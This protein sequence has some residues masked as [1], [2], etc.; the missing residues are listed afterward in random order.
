MNMSMKRQILVIVILSVFFLSSSVCLATDRLVR[1]QYLTIQDAINASTNGDIVIISPGT[2]T[3][4][5][6][7]DI[8]FGGKAITVKSTDGPET[9]I[10]DVY[11]KGSLHRGFYFH[12]NESSSSVLWGVTITSGRVSGDPAKGGGIYCSGSSPKIENCI[13]NNNSAY[14]T[15]GPSESCVNGGDAYGGAIYCDQSNAIIINCTIA[16]NS[17]RGGN[18]G[19]PKNFPCLPSGGTAYGGGIY[20]ET[21]C[22]TVISNCIIREND[23]IGGQ[24]RYGWGSV[25]GDG[26]GGGV[27]GNSTITN[28]LIYNNRAACGYSY[29]GEGFAYGGAVANNTLSISNCTILYNYAYGQMYS[30]AAIYGNSTIVNCIIWSNDAWSN[31]VPSDIVVAGDAA[32]TYSDI[33]GGYNGAGN[34]SANP[35][36]ISGPLGYYYLSQITAGQARNSPCVDS[37]S[38]T[39]VNLGMDEI[40]RAHV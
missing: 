35:I 40:G 1:S 2:Y 16:W 3:G 32:I 8:D 9:C 6:N 39:A 10:I 14:G 15:N 12:N 7:R 4:A 11:A 13:F 25:A 21:N 28:C 36:F 26:Y 24:N 29:G 5:G 23:A 33:E 31:N 17:A 38:D 34:I 37:G 18:G 30:V 19:S 27:C 20:C 22:N